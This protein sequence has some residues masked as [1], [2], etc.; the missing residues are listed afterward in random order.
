MNRRQ[1]SL[2]PHPGASGDAALLKCKKTGILSHSW[3]VFERF[4]MMNVGLHG[5]DVNFCGNVCLV[6]QGWR[7]LWQK[8]E[9]HYVI[10]KDTKR[11]YGCRSERLR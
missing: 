3:M 9:H 7:G 1:R 6:F 4:Q 10:F 11:V 8:A 2:T 5:R